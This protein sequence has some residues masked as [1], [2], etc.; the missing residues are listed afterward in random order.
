MAYEI[1]K[2]DK[3]ECLQ[4][5]LEEQA[6]SSRF[7]QVFMRYEKCLE[8]Y[9]ITISPEDKKEIENNHRIVVSACEK[10]L[11]GRLKESVEEAKKILKK[12]IDYNDNAGSMDVQREDLSLYRARTTSE[13]K[14]LSRKE[15]FHIPFNK[16]YLIGNQ[17]YSVSGVP[18]LYLGQFTYICWEEL[19][20]P[21]PYSCN[22]IGIR[23]V[24]PLKVLDMTIPYE[25]K[26]W[27]SS[28]VPIIPVL[29]S[30]S[31][32]SKK[33]RVF[34]QEYILPQLIM[35]AAVVNKE[36]IDGIKYLSTALFFSE[37]PF[38]SDTHTLKY[39]IRTHI[40][41][42]FPAVDDEFRGK[43]SKKTL[44]KSLIDKFHLTK[45]FSIWQYQL[46]GTIARAS[47]PS[48]ED[49][50]DLKLD[51]SVNYLANSMYGE[52]DK[53]FNQNEYASLEVKC[54]S[55]FKTPT[56]Q[57]DLYVDSIGAVSGEVPQHNCE[58]YKCYKWFKERVE[59]DN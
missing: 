40:N 4:S 47:I 3:E 14:S 9:K 5:F 57:Y 18:C 39:D 32:F 31:L 30:C 12:L 46:V 28:I 54:E 21:N 13:Y 25:D 16:K 41:Y 45:P 56:T 33:D 59:S 50:D 43:D 17:R 27:Q 10:Y 20:R 2:K 51:T 1:L 42:V 34:K 15:M 11:S 35:M 44:S 52:L 58:D 36:K 23:N 55:K 6:I 38:E 48:N 19:G 49:Q 8:N 22:Y 7:T 29:I 53:I 24:K 37:F 26:E